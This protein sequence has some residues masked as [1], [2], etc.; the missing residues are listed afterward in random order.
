MKNKYQTKESAEKDKTLK[1]YIDKAEASNEKFRKA[2]DADIAKQSKALS[3]L[4]QWLTKEIEKDNSPPKRIRTVT[5]DSNESNPTK[6]ARS[7]SSEEI[8][9]KMGETLYA[10]MVVLNRAVNNG[11]IGEQV[12]EQ[13]RKEIESSVKSFSY[14]QKVKDTK[15]LGLLKKRPVSENGARSFV[16]LTQDSDS[17]ISIG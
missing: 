13:Y 10:Q 15:S 8:L 3:E 11:S 6:K 16:D 5:F 17:E 9:H 7:E 4:N 14:A 1:A 2:E 12:S